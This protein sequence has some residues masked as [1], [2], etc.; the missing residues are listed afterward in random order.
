MEKARIQRIHSAP[1]CTPA[2]SAPP[3]LSGP[4]L[5][6]VPNHWPRKE[7]VSF[8]SEHVHKVEVEGGH[9]VNGKVKCGRLTNETEQNTLTVNNLSAFKDKITLQQWH[10]FFFF[11]KQNVD[12]TFLCVRNKPVLVMLHTS[13]F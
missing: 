10:C 13:A 5:T 6:G 2:L 4:S 7:N 12:L 11:T 1:L 9:F 8:E 3:C